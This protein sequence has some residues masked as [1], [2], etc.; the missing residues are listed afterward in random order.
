MDLDLGFTPATYL[1]PLR[2]LELTEDWS[3]KDV[4]WLVFA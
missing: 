4:D 1:R 2:R 3:G